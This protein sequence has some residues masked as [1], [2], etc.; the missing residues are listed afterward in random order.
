[1]IVP[2]KNLFYIIMWGLTY[3]NVTKGQ[4]VYGTLQ[5]KGFKILHNVVQN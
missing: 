3:A 1:M 5:L 2:S 4:G